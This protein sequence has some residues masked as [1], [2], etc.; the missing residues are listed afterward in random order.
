MTGPQTCNCGAV[1]V[2]IEEDALQILTGKGLRVMRHF[3][4]RVQRTTPCAEY[5]GS[6]IPPHVHYWRV[7][8]YVY[9]VNAHT[10]TT[11]RLICRECHEI[12]DVPNRLPIEIPN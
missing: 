4:G 3:F 9:N 8:M 10:T 5:R 1:T 12:T 2:D 6:P 7:A 11:V